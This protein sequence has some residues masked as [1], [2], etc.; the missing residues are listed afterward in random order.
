MKSNIFIALLALV[1][2]TQAWIVDKK[3]F[4]FKSGGSYNR[5]TIFG[6][7]GQSIESPSFTGSWWCGYVDGA[8]MNVAVKPDNM[9]WAVTNKFGSIQG[10]DAHTGNRYHDGTSGGGGS[11]SFYYNGGCAEQDASEHVVWC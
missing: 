3:E 5:V 10:C 7:N 9:V 11:Y 8:V 6:P 2:S 1:A 4:G